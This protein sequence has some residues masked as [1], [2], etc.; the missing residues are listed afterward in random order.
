VVRIIA[1]EL[2]NTILLLVFLMPCS[3]CRE[4]KKIA[5]LW[6]GG[7]QNVRKP[8]TRWDDQFF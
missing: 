6:S 4:L 1:I 5:K 8:M 7:Y 2:V 3:V